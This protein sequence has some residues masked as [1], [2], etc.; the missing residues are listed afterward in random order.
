MSL[1]GSI[2]RAYVA[3][4]LM[5]GGRSSRRGSR[6]GYG[7][8]YRSGYG[9]PYGR[10]GRPARGGFVM[11]GPFPTYSRRTRGGSR[12]TVT[13]CCLPIPLALSVGGALAARHALRS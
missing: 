10:R 7:Y 2:A 12:V 8:G 1:F 11:R 13:G 3:N 6:S 9:S 4:R 5:R